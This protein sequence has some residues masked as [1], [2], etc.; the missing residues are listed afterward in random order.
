MLHTSLRLDCKLCIKKSVDFCENIYKTSSCIYLPIYLNVCMFYQTFAECLC[1]DFNR[2]Q[3]HGFC[4][5]DMDSQVS[6]VFDF[7]IFDSAFLDIN[8][9]LKSPDVHD[10]TN[11]S[12]Q[13]SHMIIFVISCRL[14]I[15]CWPLQNCPW[16][17]LAIVLLPGASVLTELRRVLIRLIGTL[18]WML[19][20]SL[21]S[22]FFRAAQP[23]GQHGRGTAIRV[24]PDR[25]N[26]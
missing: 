5:T 26:R 7:E 15:N 13:D 6:C 1:R 8:S 14:R 10:R 9:L 24:T 19:M 22:P 4:A 23:S 3:S 20:C 12:M 2:K 16:S 17:K 18:G 21:Q 25:E 11:E